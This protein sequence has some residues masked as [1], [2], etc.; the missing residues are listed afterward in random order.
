MWVLGKLL[1]C[2]KKFEMLIDWLFRVMW[3]LREEVWWPLQLRG[4]KPFTR[5]TGFP[6]R[7]WQRCWPSLGLQKAVTLSAWIQHQTG[8]FNGTAVNA[9][10][11]VKCSTMRSNTNACA[12]FRKGHL[13]AE[14]E[15]AGRRERQQAAHYLQKVCVCKI[16]SPPRRFSWT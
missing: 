10:F 2:Q 13:V 6:G 8:V 1:G 15:M 3:S 4:M 12:L 5:R 16:K 9:F 7:Q 14:S 11:T